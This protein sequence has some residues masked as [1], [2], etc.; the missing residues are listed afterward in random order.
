MAISLTLLFPAAFSYFEADGMMHYFLDTCSGTFAIGAVVALVTR[1]FKSE[2]RVREG[3]FIVVVVWTSFVLMAATPMYL[4]RTHIAPNFD[5]S[6]AM[7]EA[8]S[9]LT[10]TGSSVIDN[11]R[12]LPLSINLWRHTIIWMGGMGILLLAV[13]ILPLLGV[14]GNQIMKG[15]MPGP[16]KEEKLTPRIANTAKAL[17]VIYISASFL[18]FLC[19]H[20]AGLSWFDAWCHAAS[21][22]SLGGFS[23]FNSG[24]IDINSPWVDLVAVVFMLFAG[25]NFATHFRVIQ[26]RSFKYYLYCPEA[27]P[28]LVVVVGSGTLISIFLYVGNDYSSLLEAFRYG[29]F[30]TVALATTTGFSS[31]DYTVWPLFLALWMLV[32]GSFSTS[33]G[34]TGGGVKLIRM[35]IL[36][37][38][39]KIELRRLLHPHGIFPV[40]LKGRVV[41]P[42]IIMSVLIYFVIYACVVLVMTTLMTISG[43]DLTTAFSA[44]F[45]C[46]ANIGP[47]LNLV[48]PANN[49]GVLN[50]IQLWILT[51]TMLIGRLEM[52]TVL[53]LFTPWFWRS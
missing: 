21:T 47:G 35:I 43:L 44:V 32:L 27:I 45:S 20:F 28:F 38:Q 14:G 18:C 52:Y 19:Y 5:F 34:S 4:A 36:V 26:R 2:L 12:G 15:E 9:G 8:M 22:L 25:I 50:D 29:I 31:A 1:P 49:Y 13:A 11:V 17:Y 46:Q 16:F 39:I 33:A 40:R 41:P 7:F 10:T 23:T 48:G 42:K 51:A 3:L 24:F 53:I 37:R 6:H 30:N